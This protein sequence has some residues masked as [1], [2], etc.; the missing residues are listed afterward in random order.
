MDWVIMVT[1]NRDNW[2]GSMNFYPQLQSLLLSRFYAWVTVTLAVALLTPAIAAQAQ[3]C[4]VEAGFSPEGSAARL[5]ERVIDSAKTSVRLAGYSFTSPDI[6]RR[7]IAARRR[8]V[9]VAVLV[10]A[11]NNTEQ[12]RSGKSQAALNLLVQAGI[13]ARTIDTYPIHHDKYIIIDGA[14]VQTGS[15]NYTLAAARYNSE[16]VLVIWNCATLANTYLKHW[17]P[18]WKQG[19]N[20]KIQY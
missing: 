13:S 12:D 19:R 17:N 6:A 11:K 14:T 5:V 4:S 15:F 1:V 9:N 16:N 7:L 8:G 20:W 18:R 3:I 10:D 2:K